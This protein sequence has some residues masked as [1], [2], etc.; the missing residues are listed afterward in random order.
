MLT[1]LFKHEIKATFRTFLWLYIAFAVIAVVNVL[2]SPQIT[3]MSHA[4][5]VNESA[6]ATGATLINPTAIQSI[7]MIMYFL[8]IA[9]I[10][11]GTFVIVILRFYRNLLGDEGYLMF[12]L[13]VSREQHIL[14]K[15]FAAVLWAICSAVLIILSVLMLLSSSGALPEIS[16]GMNELIATGVP[17]DRWISFAVIALIVSCFTGILMLYAAMA[18]GP[19][20]LK[21][22]VGGSIL[23]YIIIYV[24]S[25]IAI[26]IVTFSSIMN[27]VGFNLGPGFVREET[28]VMAES[29]AHTVT[30]TSGPMMTQQDI[31]G[32]DAVIWSCII[33]YAVIGV[34][35]WFLTQYMLKKKLNLA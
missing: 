1:T 14:S 10:A 22:R 18:I 16:K 17:I 6:Q 35:C 3:G 30:V 34:C 27:F 9:A 21:N 23:A 13:P 5:Q 29:G 12:T 2:I 7:I 8:S 26:S 33:G 15:L 11:I 25:Q 4:Y 19:N 32:I 24:A 31:A 28:A 20:L